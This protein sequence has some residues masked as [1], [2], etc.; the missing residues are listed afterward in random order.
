MTISSCFSVAAVQSGESWPQLELGAPPRAALH[1]YARLQRLQLKKPRAPPWIGR[2]PA[3]RKKGH[4]V[5]FQLYSVLGTGFDLIFECWWLFS[6][7]KPES[8][9][10]QFQYSDKVQLSGTK[11]AWCHQNLL[12]HQCSAFPGCT[13]AFYSPYGC[14]H[15]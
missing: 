14:C 7:A 9:A 12:N 3:L 6:L 2:R 11:S 5:S 15:P 10:F 8:V 13:S 4:C 1:P